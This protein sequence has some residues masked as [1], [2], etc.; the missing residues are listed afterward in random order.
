M[1]KI[2][3]ERHVATAEELLRVLSPFHDY[4]GTT[5]GMG[6]WVFRG[7]RDSAWPLLPSAGRPDAFKFTQIGVEFNPQIRG[8]SEQ[9]AAEGRAVFE[10]IS[11]CLNANL[12]VPEDSQWIRN[13]QLIDS[14]FDPKFITEVNAG[15]DWPFAL[16]RSLYA[17][18][19][20]HGQPTRLL[21]WT[22]NAF[23]AAYFAAAKVAKALKETGAPPVGTTGENVAVFALRHLVTE[24]VSAKPAWGFP[25]PPKYDRAIVEVGAPYAENPNLRA[26]QGTFTLLTF[27][28]P[29]TNEDWKIPSLDEVL[30]DWCERKFDSRDYEWGNFPFLIKFTTP[31]SQSGRLLRLLRD[32][33]VWAPTVFPNYDAVKLGL[34]ERSYWR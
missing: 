24:Y 9:L 29:R 3:E 30:L 20:H 33:Q 26:Q 19:Q 21:D 15:V 12:A 22:R 8:L 10:F 7:Q 23:T 28:T 6:Y 34:A 11:A 4:W 2:I 17:L 14:A 25:P 18:A 13:P 1:A 16:H 27:T 31:L 32:A 5:G